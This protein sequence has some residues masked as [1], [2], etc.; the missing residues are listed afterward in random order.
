LVDTN[1]L[2]AGSP[3]LRRGSHA[4]LVEWMDQE[5][6][7]LF[8]PTVA[9]AEIVGGIAKSRREGAARKAL[10]LEEWLENL[11]RLYSARTL[12]LDIGAARALGALTDLARARGIVA[13]WADM[14]IAS[15]ALAHGLVVLTRN[16]R[17]FAPL[18]IEAIDPYE[19]LPP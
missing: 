15:V 13:G 6:A 1:V 4:A 7:R 11:L 16:R 5:S 10:A 18:G 19:A 8:L 14:A 12:G 9:V 17:H 2:S 3:A